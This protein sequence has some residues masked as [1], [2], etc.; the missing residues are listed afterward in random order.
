[1]S[2]T[3]LENQTTMTK[4]QSQNN[5]GRPMNRSNTNTVKELSVNATTKDYLTLFGL[6][7]MIIFVSMILPS[8]NI[9][10]YEPKTI[11]TRRDN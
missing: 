10:K 11:L 3:L 6:G 5:F 4:E 9:I 2:K 7:Y 1:M 8:I